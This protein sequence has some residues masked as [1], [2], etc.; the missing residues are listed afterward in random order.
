M[1]TQFS[2]LKSTT[3]SAATVTTLARA[4]RRLH[5]EVQ[6][7]PATQARAATNDYFNSRLVTDYL[8]D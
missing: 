6:S 4:D 5:T 7:P 1:Y 8:N 3:G 2:V